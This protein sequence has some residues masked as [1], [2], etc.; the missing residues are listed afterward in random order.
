MSRD[1]SPFLC[2]GVHVLWAEMSWH[3]ELPT[4]REAGGSSCWTPHPR[5]LQRGPSDYHHSRGRTDT[6]RAGCSVTHPTRP[7]LPRTTGVD[8]GGIGPK[9]EA[10]LQEMRRQHP[11]VQVRPILPAVLEFE[12]DTL[13]TMARKIFHSCLQG[14]P[15]GVA[16]GLGGCTN[17][18]L[19]MYA[20][21]DFAR[22][23]VPGDVCHALMLATMTGLQKRDGGVRRI[24]TGTSFHRLVANVLARQFSDASEA[25]CAPFQFAPSSRA[26]TDCVGHAVRV[27]IELNPR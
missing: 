3:R 22:G 17:E 6:Q 1:L 8:R 26:G 20:A 27:A 25:T 21:E 12:P 4:S 14:V 10:T 9:S 18:M 19:L 5:S 23:H 7:G 24:A 13:L 16:P 11:Q 2:H 15:S